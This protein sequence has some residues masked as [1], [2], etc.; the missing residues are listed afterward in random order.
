MIKLLV[1]DDEIE[2]CD[3]VKSFFSERDFDVYTAHN[4]DEAVALVRANMPQIV[5]LD[6]KMPVKDGMSTLKEL[7]EMQNSPKIIMVTAVDDVDKMQ[8]AKECGAVEYIT[9][10]LV[11]EDLEKSVIGLAQG[12]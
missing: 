12:M 3:F 10:P 2:I 4:G 7:C 1:V 5:L 6:M 8:T 11:L 9:K